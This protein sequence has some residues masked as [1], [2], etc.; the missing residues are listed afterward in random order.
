MV[1]SSLL[2]WTEFIQKNLN[3]QA[4]QDIRFPRA[5]PY[6]SLIEIGVLYAL[7]NIVRTTSRSGKEANGIRRSAVMMGER[8]AQDLTQLRSGAKRWRE[9]WDWLDSLVLQG[10]AE[11][12]RVLL[13]LR[14]NT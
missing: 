14:V 1:P 5:G 12:I 3:T 8:L 10:G 2:R 9:Q 13:C 11:T 7:P 6:Q 4:P